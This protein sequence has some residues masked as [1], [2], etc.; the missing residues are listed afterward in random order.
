MIYYISLYI[1]Y[2]P[3]FDKDFLVKAVGWRPEVFVFVFIFVFVFVI[4]FVFVFVLVSF[5]L[6]KI[7]SPQLDTVVVQKAFMS[8]PLPFMPV[9]KIILQINAIIL[10]V[11]LIM[12]WRQSQK[13][14]K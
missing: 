2:F 8:P 12:K 14:K 5:I 6:D 7:G 11:Q 1:H 13:K 4:V 9:L 10:S 3:N